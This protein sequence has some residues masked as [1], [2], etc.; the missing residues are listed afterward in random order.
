MILV[1]DIHISL[2][3][4]RHFLAGIWYKRFVMNKVLHSVIQRLM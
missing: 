1:N 2:K 3:D 4:L